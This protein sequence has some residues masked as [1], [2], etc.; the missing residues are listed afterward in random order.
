MSKS[1]ASALAFGVALVV[2]LFFTALSINAD[3][4]DISTLSSATLYARL[5]YHDRNPASV[6]FDSGQ[7]VS[8]HLPAVQYDITY[9]SLAVNNDPDWFAVHDPRSMIVDLGAKQLGDFKETPSFPASKSRQQPMPLKRPK[10]VD[11]S[12]GSKAI[13]PYQQFV[14]VKEGHVYLMKVWRERRKIY[15]LFRVDSLRRADN[16]RLSWKKVPPPVDDIER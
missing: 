10:V 2:G 14:Q 4:Q 3:A 15:I 13:S 12:A 7:T 11:A 16:C 8:V 5:I 1:K 9:G 6:D